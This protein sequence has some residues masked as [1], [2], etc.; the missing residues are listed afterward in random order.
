[1]NW[2]LILTGEVILVL[3][4]ECL[5][6]FK[7]AFVVLHRLLRSPWA[8]ASS[9]LEKSRGFFTS[10][11]FFLSLLSLWTFFSFWRSCLREF[12]IPQLLT[13]HQKISETCT[14]SRSRDLDLC[15]LPE[16]PESSSRTVNG[17]WI[18][19]GCIGGTGGVCGTGVRGAG[20][21][22]VSGACAEG[23][24]RSRDLDR[25]RCPSLELRLESDRNPCLH[26]PK[27]VSE[28]MNHAGS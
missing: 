6:T 2:M 12:V 3:E 8:C 26:F 28:L 21:D 22:N 11:V 25:C 20:I 10:A 24:T 23:C 13:Q 16:Q 4:A 17:S 15:R 19:I 1:M 27:S 18:T 5:K 14:A 9:P 7:V